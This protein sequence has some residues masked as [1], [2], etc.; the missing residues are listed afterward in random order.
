MELAKVEYMEPPVKSKSAYAFFT[1]NNGDLAA[2]ELEK[3]YFSEGSATT[4]KFNNIPTN[5][6]HREAHLRKD[7]SKADVYYH[8]PNG[9]KL[10]STPD[11]AHFLEYISSGPGA[12]FK[13][14][15]SSEAREREE[16]M[17]FCD[18]IS[19]PR[20]DCYYA[21]GRICEPALCANPRGRKGC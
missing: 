6:F 2:E 12:R 1:E 15:R 18:D 16:G 5:G 21:N 11:V 19:N 13:K 3:E 17:W 8:T 4:A 20:D 14:V 10:R 9:T 7:G